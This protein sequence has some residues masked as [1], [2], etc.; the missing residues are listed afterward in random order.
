MLEFLLLSF[1]CVRSA[2]ASNRRICR[3]I[4][5]VSGSFVRFRY[6]ESMWLAWSVTFFV[7]VY[8]LKW[9]IGLFPVLMV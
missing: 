2:S 6:T 8:K 7:L 1:Q 9:K 4:S 5:E 3:N